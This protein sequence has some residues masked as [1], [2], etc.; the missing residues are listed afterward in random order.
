MDNKKLVLVE[1]IDSAMES[2][3]WVHRGEVNGYSPSRCTSVGWIA[4]SD[5]ERMVLYSDEGGDQVGRVMIIPS[6]CI[7]KITPLE[8]K[9]PPKR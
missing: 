8:M 2:D 9:K 3:P 6:A 7:Q 5:P 4:V 1:W